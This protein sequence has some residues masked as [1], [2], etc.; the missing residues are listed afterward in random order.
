MTEKALQQTPIDATGPGLGTLKQVAS[1]ICQGK[2]QVSFI[3]E[4][5]DQQNLAEPPPHRYA[6][7]GG[8]L[9][10]WLSNRLQLNQLIT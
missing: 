9:D 5:I 4:H 3:D 6:T 10:P 8:G 2:P 1:L 7:R